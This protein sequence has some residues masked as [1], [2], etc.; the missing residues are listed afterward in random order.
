MTLDTRLTEAAA[1]LRNTYEELGAPALDELRVVPFAPATA[2]PPRQRSRKLTGALAAAM[3]AVALVSA[4]VIF[5]PLSGDDT[6][7]VA[8]T[9]PTVPTPTVPPPPTTT[10]AATAEPASANAPSVVSWTRVASQAAFASTG[11]YT[12]MNAVTVGGP[13]LVA[14]GA[15]CQGTCTNYPGWENNANLDA[16]VWTSAD[17]ENWDRVAMPEEVAGGPG[18]Q[19]LL[20]VVAAGPGLVAL[21]YDDPNYDPRLAEDAG[22]AVL[23]T[24]SV[25]WVSTDGTEWERLLDAE[26]AYSGTE[27]VRIAAITPGGP[28]LV[29]V[30][31]DGTH[32]AVW[33]S[34][35]GIEWTRVP[36]DE[37]VFGGPY[38]IGMS[39]VTERDGVIIAVG[40][41]ENGT[42]WET[43]IDNPAETRWER[44]AV[45]RSLDG[46]LWER[47]DPDNP[48]FGGGQVTREDPTNPTGGPS[49]ANLVDAVP[50]GFVA[51]GWSQFDRAVWISPDGLAWTR[52]ADD[53]N[54]WVGG[55][56]TSRIEGFITD[57][58]RFTA[59]PWE[60]P[61]QEP[62]TW[63]NRYSVVIDHPLIVKADGVSYQG[64]LVAVGF[65]ATEAAVWIGVWEE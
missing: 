27:D 18:D 60:G 22:S 57:G 49:E 52:I 32:A 46:L 24:S 38:D 28:G 48:A 5:A 40:W 23:P 2:E 31:Q 34:S 29:A 1:E 12:F 9:L 59:L 39:D 50:G 58:Q 43:N 15:D 6:P 47:I 63:D 42:T 7:D 35:D 41:D 56:V 10:E 14:V 19:V 44:V 4:A 36:H 8:V 20:D 54:S 26:A 53:D 13:G 33:V 37:S 16:A 64:K 3:V 30:G 45:W 55:K 51:S 61:L 25:F 17:G 65:D 11:D 21:G 62:A